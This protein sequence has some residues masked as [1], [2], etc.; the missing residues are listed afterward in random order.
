MSKFVVQYLW[1]VISGADECK[2]IC[3]DQCVPLSGQIWLV[4]DN[5]L[6]NHSKSTELHQGAHFHHFFP[7]LYPSNRVQT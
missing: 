1:H 6:E 4:V 2:K 3:P 5:K 7:D